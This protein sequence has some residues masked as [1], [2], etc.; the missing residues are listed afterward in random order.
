MTTLRCIAIAAALAL[1]SSGRP[2]RA[3]ESA[4]EAQGWLSEM[5]VGV[6]AHDKAPIIADVE[7]GADLNIELLFASPH[8]LRRLDA[9][10]PIVGV[11]LA[12]EGTSYA[13]AALNWQD[14]FGSRWFLMGSLGLAVHDGDPLQESEQ[15]LY[16]QET[17]KALG[18]RVNF[19]VAVGAGYRLSRRWNVAAHYEH[20]SNAT[21]CET[22][23]GL[24]SIGIRVGRVF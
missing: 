3:E 23:E 21:L 20:L 16:E 17:E 5:R 1:A 7:S 12:S 15:T 19:Y 18:C 8:A 9:P 22:N 4:G 10:R 2:A 13:Y 6:L 11:T 24:E 14:E